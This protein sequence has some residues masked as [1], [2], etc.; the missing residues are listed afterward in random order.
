MP[1]LPDPPEPWPYSTPQ[2]WESWRDFLATSS[3]PAAAHLHTLACAELL[4]IERCA[5]DPPRGRP[6]LVPREPS[7][8]VV[9][10]GRPPRSR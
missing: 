1:T 6:A 3:A 5:S 8:N 7:A 4:R 2:Q 9:V 10:L